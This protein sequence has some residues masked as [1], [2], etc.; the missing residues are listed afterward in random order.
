MC[1]EIRISIS[2]RKH[3]QMERR[4]RIGVDVICYVCVAGV[5]EKRQ[6]KLANVLT[7]G[8]SRSCC[9]LLKMDAEY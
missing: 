9:N 3:W 4:G 8:V 2:Y 5:Q 7:R 6:M 1:R